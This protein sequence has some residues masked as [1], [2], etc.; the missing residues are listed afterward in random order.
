[1]TNFEVFLDDK[2]IF[3]S[4]SHWLHPV[5]ELENTLQKIDAKPQLLYVRDKIIG[6]AA[7]LLLVRLNI[8]N[9]HAHLLS[10]P[11]RDILE[12]YKV[13]YSFDML[14]DKIGCQTED[15]LEN[16]YDLENAYTLIK[17]KI[18]NSKSN[19]NSP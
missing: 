18:K 16:E 17:Q 12:Y 2:C 7:A 1:M 11:G 15:L 4:D 3:Q 19:N 13:A 5:F 6:R 9:I 10:K 8:K 14:V